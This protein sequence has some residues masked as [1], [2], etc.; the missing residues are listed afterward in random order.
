LSRVFTASYQYIL[1]PISYLLVFSIFHQEFFHIHK[2]CT[3]LQVSIVRSGWAKF[4][5]HV[6]EGIKYEPEQCTAIIDSGMTD[7][8]GPH[9]KRSMKS[10]KQLEQQSKQ[11]K[12][13]AL[14]TYPNMV[15]EL[16]KYLGQAF[17]QAYHTVFDYRVVGLHKSLTQITQ[18][19]ALLKQQNKRRKMKEI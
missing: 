9:T 5:G 16:H 18:K 10:M 8:H 4:L 11:E 12:L 1:F 15:Q 6:E 2:D 7:I 14:R 13:N 3:G 19:S 17:M